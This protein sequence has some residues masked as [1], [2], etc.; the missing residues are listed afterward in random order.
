MIGASLSR[1]VTLL[2]KTPLNPRLKSEDG[3]H[4]LVDASIPGIL[5]HTTPTTALSDVIETWEE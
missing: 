5:A 4:V 2:K 1:R 3:A